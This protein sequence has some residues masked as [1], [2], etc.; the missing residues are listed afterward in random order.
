[1]LK[2]SYLSL[3]VRF[4]NY[5]AGM[6]MYSV[7]VQ[8]YTASEI[9]SIVNLY[10]N[11]TVQDH[12]ETPYCKNK[13]KISLSSYTFRIKNC[14]NGDKRC[15]FPNKPLSPGAIMVLHDECSFKTE[16]DSLDFSTDA[17]EQKNDSLHDVVIGFHCFGMYFVQSISPK[18][19]C[20][21]L[22]TMQHPNL[23]VCMAIVVK[24]NQ[25]A[26]YH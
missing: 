25:P 26:T 6:S 12:L 9:T 8:T 14:N 11:G 3:S 17:K 2:G 5:L 21:H 7:A 23:P 13:Q 16:C 4:F 15:Q 22:Y 10:E 18:Q 20:I 1:M 24:I 19:N